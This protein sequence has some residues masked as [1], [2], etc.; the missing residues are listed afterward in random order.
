MKKRERSRGRAVKIKEAG[1][2]AR[3][4]A[5]AVSQSLLNGKGSCS[6]FV[7]ALVLHAVPQRAMDVGISPHHRLILCDRVVAS[8]SIECVPP[9]VIIV[10]V[11]VCERGVLGSVRAVL[12]VFWVFALSSSALRPRCLKDTSAQS[13]FLSS[14]ASIV[15]SSS[16]SASDHRC[17]CFFFLVVVVCRQ[18]A[19]GGCLLLF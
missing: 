5:M 3:A 1:W 9:P 2:G 8:F 11:S 16:S 15:S 12:F 17:S 4:R 7:W 10:I 14:C 19:R 13:S 6:L 18:C